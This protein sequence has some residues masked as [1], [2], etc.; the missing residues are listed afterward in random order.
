MWSVQL[1]CIELLPNMYQNVYNARA[2]RAVGLLT[3][4]HRLFNDVSVAV[5]VLVCLNARAAARECR[6]KCNSHV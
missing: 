1:V 3:A 6:V 5:A 4:L 2:D